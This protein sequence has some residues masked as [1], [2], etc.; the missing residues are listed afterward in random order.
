LLLSG[1]GLGVSDNLEVILI[2]FNDG[3]ALLQKIAAPA[4]SFDARKELNWLDK[5]I[6]CCRSPRECFWHLVLEHLKKN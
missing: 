3:L 6:C 5:I 4:V 1:N 2:V